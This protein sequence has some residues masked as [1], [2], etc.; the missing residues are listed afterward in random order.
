MGRKIAGAWL[1]AVPFI[2]IISFGAHE[3]GLSKM[4]GLLAF[5]LVG[6]A[7]IGVGVYLMED[8]K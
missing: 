5:E 2:G 7:F 1:V 4:I 6:A 8:R 3:V